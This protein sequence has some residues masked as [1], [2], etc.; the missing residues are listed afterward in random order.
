VISSKAFIELKNIYTN[1]LKGFSI[2]IPLKALTVIVGQSGS[3]KSSLAF[4]TLAKIG[5]QRLKHLLNYSSPVLAEE[6][7]KAEVSGALPPVIALAQGVR[8]WYPYKLVG[9]L[10]GLY[11]FLNNRF[12]REGEYFCSACK[13]YT[14]YT[15]FTEVIS[16]FEA[17]P[18]GTKFYFLLPLRMTS[19]EGL[20]YLYEQGFTRFLVEGIEWDVSEMG[21]P[22]EGKEIHLLLDRMIKKSEALSRLFETSAFRER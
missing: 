10:L 12:M 16:F 5:L 2:K 3:G 20:R 18:E 14:R 21:F 15:P 7:I 11:P 6:G 1:N 17:L 9:E 19:K 22:P 8:D 4:D 13:G